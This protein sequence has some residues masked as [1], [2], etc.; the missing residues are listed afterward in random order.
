MAT[1]RI[2]TYCAMCTCRCGVL[3]TVE[4]GRLTKVVADS[5]HPNAC[6]CVKGT[7]APEIVS[8]PER[9]QYPLRRTR[10]KGDPDPGWVRISWDEALALATS[11]LL[12]IKA[13]YGPEAVVFSRATPSNATGD[14]VDWLV[15]QRRIKRRLLEMVAYAAWRGGVWDANVLPARCAPG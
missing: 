7:A 2:H 5:E 9:L 10:P 11:R 3:A 6:I 1:E 13:R 15:L 14:F 4:D 12:G 8:S